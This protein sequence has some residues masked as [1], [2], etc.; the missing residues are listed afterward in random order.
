M[1]EHDQFLSALLENPNDQTMRLVYADWLEDRDDPRA[2]YLRLHSRYKEIPSDSVQRSELHRRLLELLPTLP[3]WWLAIVTG[4]RASAKDD[5]MIGPRIEEAARAIGQAEKR[6]DKDG[7]ELTIIDA[8]TNGRT[9]A[10]AYLESR[11]KWIDRLHDIHYHLYLRDAAGHTVAW[12]PHTYN[13]YFGCN[14]QFLEWYGDRV[15]FIYEEKHNTYIARFGFDGPAMFRDI[16]YPWI[17]DGCEIVFRRWRAPN[18]ERLSI[19]DLELLPPFSESE[20]GERD[21]LIEAR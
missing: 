2:E 15:V 7:Y 4:L 6:T 16:E 14:P 3:P 18:L 1:N 13:P 5:R 19:P 11:S 17:L 12:E 20:A 8:A 9:G 21:L 10:I